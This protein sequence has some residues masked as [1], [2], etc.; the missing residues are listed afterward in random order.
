MSPVSRIS[1]TSP[2]SPVSPW[3]LMRHRSR[4]REFTRQASLNDNGDEDVGDGGDVVDVDVD[5]G[6]ENVEDG[7][8]VGVRKS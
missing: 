7:V 6:D 2:V 1:P 8:G 3:A 4:W 5:A